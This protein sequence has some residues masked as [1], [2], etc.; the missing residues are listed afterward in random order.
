MA[1]DNDPRWLNPAFA[2]AYCVLRPDSL[3][4]GFYGWPA[5]DRFIEARPRQASASF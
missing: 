3:Y 1:N 4:V 2:E 5:T